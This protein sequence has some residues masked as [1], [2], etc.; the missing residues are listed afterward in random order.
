[1]RVLA[2]C[3]LASCAQG[4]EEAPH[5]GGAPGDSATPDCAV[6]SYEGALCEGANAVRGD[7]ELVDDAVARCLCTVDGHLK[8]RGPSEASLPLLTSVGGEL[9]LGT[10]LTALSAPGLEEVG[11]LRFSN[12]KLLVSA[13]LPSLH[14]VA[15]DLR[16]EGL[17]AL[18]ELELEG[19]QSVAGDL[20]VVDNLNL[21]RL[22]HPRLSSV[23][24][25]VSVED[26]SYLVDWAGT[27]A[28]SSLG[29]DLI[30]RR[31]PGLNPM[32]FGSLTAAAELAL[33][34]LDGLVVLDGFP[35]LTEVRGSLRISGA[36]QLQRIEGFGALKRVG[37]AVQIITNPALTQI[38]AFHALEELGL[39]GDLEDETHWLRVAA[40]FTLSDIHGF[41]A[42]REAG[43][44]SVEADL[45]LLAFDLPALEH[46]RHSIDLSDNDAMTGIG[47]FAKLETVGGSL[48]LNGHERVTSVHGFPRLTSVGAN[49]EI[50]D[51]PLL[52]TLGGFD[53]LNDVAGD[54]A[55]TGNPLLP[56][57]EATA[58]AE[59]IESVGGEISLDPG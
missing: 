36:A 53:A 33:E 52:G 14:T 27:E 44:V 8:L 12:A 35:R 29:G 34:D 21:A 48:L 40:N 31:N 11:S 45:R 17:T 9:S 46:A 58:L 51:N 4:K 22:H 10:G 56:K 3:V 6:L 7:L 13:A 23:G 54:V 18:L 37:G 42:L 26:N 39:D 55:L 28:L 43:G 16:F 57:A 19:L 41:G 25:S 49:L 20:V 1:M 2:L 30:A 24:G 59:G 38:D 32:D 15:A 47:G 5:Q 50:R